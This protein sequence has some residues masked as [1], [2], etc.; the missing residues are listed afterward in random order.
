MLERVLAEV[1]RGE[2]VTK[3][4]GEYRSVTKYGRSISI[5]FP[6]S[7]SASYM[8][9]DPAHPDPQARTLREL[10]LPAL[11]WYY[12]ERMES[13]CGYG[14]PTDATSGETLSDEAVLAAAD[15]AIFIE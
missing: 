13:L 5:A 6:S 1:E 3:V 9:L 4:D 10:W 12:S 14:K 15:F 8:W 11:E 2:Y 7:A